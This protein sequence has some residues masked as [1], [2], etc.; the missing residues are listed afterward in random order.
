MQAFT[1]YASEDK[2]TDRGNTAGKKIGR[3][4]EAQ[5]LYKF[6]NIDK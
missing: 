5:L 6:F 1:F 4:L 3:F 2:L